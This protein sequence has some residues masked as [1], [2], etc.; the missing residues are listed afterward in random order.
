MNNKRL[1]VRPE[2]VEELLDLPRT[3]VRNMLRDGELPSIRV[4]RSV[5]VP[6]EALRE[7][8][9]QRQSSPENGSEK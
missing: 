2:G 8:I 5:R 6:V 4:G 1:L 7:W 9:K 3:R